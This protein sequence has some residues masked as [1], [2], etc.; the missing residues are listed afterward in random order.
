MHVRIILPCYERPELAMM[1]ALL[2]ETQDLSANGIHWSI[3]AALG[4]HP[5]ALAC[6]YGVRAALED[7]CTHVLIWGADNH[8]S[9]PGAVR[10]LLEKKKDVVG[11]A[12][13]KRNG[14]GQF[15]FVP[16]E[17]GEHE[18]ALV[19]E[20]GG[21]AEVRRCGSGFMLID[22]RVF[23]KL[24]APRCPGRDGRDV[25]LYFR[26]G[27][28][29]E[30]IVSEDYAFCDLVRAAGM[31]VWMDVYTQHVHIGVKAYSGRLA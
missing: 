2:A 5:V 15:C 10:N 28:D 23:G 3:D 14:S 27:Y 22:T 1:M 8:P 17:M 19:V 30:G 18:F 16:L 9:K 4:V 7:K 26:D 31:K 11:S 13:V 6:N 29:R 20:D 21:L 12:I 25:G 24:D